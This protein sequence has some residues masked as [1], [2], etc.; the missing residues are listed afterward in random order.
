MEDEPDE[1]YGT[2]E[3]NEQAAMDAK[4]T[5][6]ELGEDR[7]MGITNTFGRELDA[8]R[9]PS[10][11]RKALT[12]IWRGGGGCYYLVRCSGPECPT[13]KEVE[14]FGIPKRRALP[15]LEGWTYDKDGDWLCPECTREQ[16]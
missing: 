2:A 11:R 16:E 10:G 12:N 6:R 3:D 4:K 15:L 1:W 8:K 9:R 7:R 5:T 14:A 13:T